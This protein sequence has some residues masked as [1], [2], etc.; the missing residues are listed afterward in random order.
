MK[1]NTIGM[2]GISFVEFAS[3]SP[4]QMEKTFYEFGF[5]FIAERDDNKL[6]RQNHINFLLNASPESY[7]TYFA[8]THGPC[9]SAMAWKFKDAK[10][11]YALALER[12]A[13]A[14]LEGDYPVPAIYGIGDSVIY[15]VEE[16]DLA[17]TFAPLGFMEAKHPHFTKEKGFLAIDHLTNNVVK[18][19]M[20]DWS[21]FYKK[22]FEFTEV[23]SFHI[24]GEKTGLQ[25]YAL[26]SPC[27]TFCIP[28]NE[29]DEKKSQINE[30]LEEYKG[31]GIQHL[32]FLTKDILSSLHEL[33]GSSIQT[34]DISEKYYRTVFDR[35]PHVKEDKQEIERR[36]VLVDGDEEGYLLQIFTK[37]LFG[38]IF[39]ELIQ[40][41]NHHSF[42][43]G[44]FQA[45]FE[46]IER[47]Q[48]K[49]GVFNAD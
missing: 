23:R 43:E 47:D 1:T 15:F 16:A 48:E 25:S 40:R 11:S 5:S 36:Q 6:F 38:P 30:Y 10:A 21:D 42:G 24:Q 9:I 19:T 17:D 33:E 27:G 2:R 32:A 13:R 8:N 3:P 7:A 44:N 45:L 18:G 28:I 20:K 29:A 39:I 12:G 4:I 22:I 26:R 35:V 14:F 41:K 49:R 46:S 37:N 34:L 31:A